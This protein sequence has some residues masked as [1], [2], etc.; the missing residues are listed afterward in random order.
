[1]VEKFINIFEGLKRA[2]GCTYINS[3]PKNGTKL[4]TKSFVKRE[5]VTHEHFENHLKGVEPTLGIIPI[6]EN[7][8]CKWGCIDVDSYA[9]FDHLKLLK[10]IQKLELPLVVC[11]S[12]SG[13]AHIFLF[14]KEYV[15][16]KT[17]RDKLNQIKAILGFGNAEVF[18]KQIELKSEEDTGNFLNLPYFQGD[19]TT[20]YAFKLDGSA[21][22]LEE[23]YSLHEC[24][25]IK[26]K[27]VSNI[28]I[29]REESE[30][31]DAPPCIETMALE[32]NF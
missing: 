6:N 12:K 27:D 31:K 21:A 14:I 20:R 26:P 3:A 24:Y 2:H 10:K 19:K 1:M 7:D 9:G 15:E 13:G 11:R 23:F 32:G 29:K 8:L 28:K 4:K 17:V 5:I 30:F 16:A 22:N 18:P 25:S